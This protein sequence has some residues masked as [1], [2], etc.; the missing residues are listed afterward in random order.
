MNRLL[1]LLVCLACSTQAATTTHRTPRKGVRSA[2]DEAR[3]N[4]ASLT[5]PVRPGSSGAAVLR[6]QILLD[7]AKFSCGEIDGSYGRNLG[8]AIKGYQ[9]AHDMKATGLVGAAMWKLLNADEAPALFQYTITPEDV[10]GPFE[11]IPADML[12]K[13]NLKVL[14]YESPLEGIAEKLHINPQLLTKLNP[15]KKF[16]E[17]GVEITAPNVI[18]AAPGKAA[19]VVVNGTDRT[20]AALDAAGKI[21]ALYPATIGSEHDPLPV[22]DWKVTI[23]QRKPEFFY[24]SDLFWDANE[25]HAKAKIPPGPNNPVGVVWIGL[26]KE[27][28]GIHGTPEPHNI[29]HT[30]SHGCIRLTNWNA[31]EL[32]QMVS[33]GTPATL[34]E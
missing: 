32:A 23:I 12:E 31:L 9:Q 6:A 33:K 11:K 19:S 8:M 2:F 14:N 17:A 15:G 10:A 29:G 22:G 21:L 20:V 26:S 3:V 27:H 30:Q 24:N 1:P 16:D 28:Y 7:R 18:T 25:Q 5:T 13:A 34:K 4:N